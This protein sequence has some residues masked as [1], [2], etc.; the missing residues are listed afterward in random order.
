MRVEVTAAA[1]V[2]RAS[3]WPRSPESEVVLFESLR[4]ENGKRIVEKEN[5]IATEKTNG[6]TL[7]FGTFDRT[8]DVDEIDTYIY[9]YICKGI[10][11]TKCK[12]AICII[13]TLILRVINR[14]ATL[15]KQ[16]AFDFEGITIGHCTV[17]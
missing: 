10:I 17:Q 7:F 8:R 12:Y 6:R 15:W 5:V 4:P 14:E 11:V 16:S 1:M 3:A 2:L 9:M 13:C